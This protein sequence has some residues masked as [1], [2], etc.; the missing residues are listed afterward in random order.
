MTLEAGFCAAAALMEMLLQSHGGVIRVF[1]AMPDHWHNACFA[2]LRAEGAFLVTSRMCDRKVQYVAITSEVGGRCRVRNPW[3]GAGPV[4][5][6]R[7]DGPEEDMVRDDQIVEFER[8]VVARHVLSPHGQRT[9]G[10]DRTPP[11]PTRAPCERNWFGV[12][13]QARF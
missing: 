13:R 1:P 3:P 5:V 10:G 12:K 11:T 9:T 4:R 8:R 7:E 2:G 6:S